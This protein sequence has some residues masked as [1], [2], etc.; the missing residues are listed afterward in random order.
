VVATDS[1]F[2]VGTKWPKVEGLGGKHRTLNAE[3]GPRSSKFTGT[4][5]TP[6]TPLTHYKNKLI[7]D[8][9]WRLGGRVARGFFDMW[10]KGKLKAEVAA[11]A[12]DAVGGSGAGNCYRSSVRV[13]RF[14]TRFLTISSV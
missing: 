10:L 11:S 6:L 14:A 4:H 2:K 9:L 1:E 13:T 12:V 5:T 8:S 3:G 7:G